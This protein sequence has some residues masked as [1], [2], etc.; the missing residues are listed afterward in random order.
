MQVERHPL[1][2]NRACHLADN[3]SDKQH[4]PTALP[5]RVLRDWYLRRAYPH[6]KT[7]LLAHPHRPEKQTETV[8]AATACLRMSIVRQ[9]LYDR[10]HVQFP[11][12]QRIMAGA[13]QGSIREIDDN[14]RPRAL[15]PTTRQCGSGVAFLPDKACRYT[16]N[17]LELDFLQR[18]PTRPKPL[19]ILRFQRHDEQAKVQNLP[20][21]VYL[22]PRRLSSRAR[23]SVSTLGQSRA[24]NLNALGA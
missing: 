23:G 21:R 12:P 5:G 20:V 6:D 11:A 14:K 17:G 22:F 16:L 19:Q 9:I 13:N 7:M 4:R 15:L 8:L 2:A 24:Y 1:A 3:G 18:R 10:G